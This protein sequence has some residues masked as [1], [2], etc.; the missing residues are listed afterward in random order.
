MARSFQEEVL[1]EAYIGSIIVA[2]RDLSIAA[3]NC[4]TKTNN[5]KAGSPTRA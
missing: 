2:P 5:Q 1:L 3:A 4:P